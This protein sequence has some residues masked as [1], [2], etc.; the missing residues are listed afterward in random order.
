[1]NLSNVMVDYAKHLALVGWYL[2]V[3]RHRRPPEHR[4]IIFGQARSGSTLLVDLLEQVC[5]I[6]CDGEIL[7]ARV[8]YPGLQVAARCAR[9][10][11]PCY[12]CKI[13]SYQLSGH[14]P[15]RDAKTFVKD[16]WQSGYAFIYLRRENL[17][18]QALSEMRARVHGFHSSKRDTTGRAGPVQIDSNKLLHWLQALEDRRAFEERLLTGI[19]FLELQYEEDLEEQSA[20]Q[21][22]VDKVCKYLGVPPGRVTAGLSKLSP[23]P[24]QESVV[25]HE[26]IEAALCGTPYAK[27]L[28][29]SF[30][31]AMNGSGGVTSSGKTT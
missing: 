24:L 4:F 8:P 30:A 15:I 1:M 31:D 2:A 7:N 22:T 23:R 27:Y 5:G 21:R 16:L 3:G 6:H 13:L 25:N 26:E 19:S 28:D 18:R 14:Q 29:D 20:H 11:A 9:S 10:T 17:V 12:G